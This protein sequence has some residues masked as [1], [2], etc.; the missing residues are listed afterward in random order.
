MSGDLSAQDDELL[1]LSSI[2]DKDFSQVSEE[3]GRGGELAIH[4]QMKGPIK[5]ECQE[6]L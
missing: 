2:F 1:V 3:D 4:L 5:L 6:G